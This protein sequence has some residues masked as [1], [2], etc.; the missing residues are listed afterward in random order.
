MEAPRTCGNGLAQRSALP[1]RL[2]ALAAAIA[3]V[4]EGHQES[5]DPTDEHARTEQAANE[6]VIGDFRNLASQLRGVANRMAS[7]RDLPPARH[8]QDAAAA[9][10]RDPL[11]ALVDSERQ[12]LMV[13]ENWIKEDASMLTVISGGEA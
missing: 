1:A 7:Y 3:D 12:V 2:S 13:L 9:A 8:N 5:L 11:V 6:A 10:M 4:L